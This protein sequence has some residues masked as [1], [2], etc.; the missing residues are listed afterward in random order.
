MITNSYIPQKTKL[1]KITCFLILHKIN[2]NILN[3]FTFISFFLTPILNLII[4][5][6]FML[7]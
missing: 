4:I 3:I 2:K 6:D 5:I 1:K 7:V